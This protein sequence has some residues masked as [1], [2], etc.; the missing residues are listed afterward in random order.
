MQ[1]CTLPL[2]MLICDILT[3]SVCL[4][5]F[6]EIRLLY[7]ECNEQHFL[8]SC[9]LWLRWSE[10]SWNPDDTVHS[11]RQLS[12]NDLYIPRRVWQTR[13]WSSWIFPAG[14]VQ[15]FDEQWTKRHLKIQLS[16]LVEGKWHWWL[17]FLIN[18]ISELR[19]DTGIRL[20]GCRKCESPTK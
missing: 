7:I 2:L 18:I 12:M 4:T 9:V 16:L 11:Q 20:Q 3:C 14:F 8:C 13:I 17:E 15:N 19:S 5:D 6:D 10:R 1:L